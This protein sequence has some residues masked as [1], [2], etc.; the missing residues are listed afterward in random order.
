MTN[1]LFYGDNLEVR[2][3]NIAKLERRPYPLRSVEN[4]L[5]LPNM[6]K[7]DP[8]GEPNHLRSTARLGSAAKKD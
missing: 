5:R 3:E 6:T 2:R 1:K 8:W 7:L 4:F